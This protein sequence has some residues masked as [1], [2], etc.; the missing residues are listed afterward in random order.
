M[1]GIARRRDGTLRHRNAFGL[2]GLNGQAVA[3]SP[4]GRRIAVLGDF[5]G[6]VLVL[7]AVGNVLRRF[8]RLGTTANLALDFMDD[9]AVVIPA[10][11][12]LPAAMLQIVPAAG[13]APARAIPGPEP[14]TGSASGNVAQFYAVSADGSLAACLVDGAHPDHLTMADLRSGRIWNLDLKGILASYDQIG[15]VALSADARQLAVGTGENRI[16]LLDPVSGRLSSQF[17]VYPDNVDAGLDSIAFSPDGSA[18]RWASRC[19]PNGM[20][21]ADS[22]PGLTIWSIP[23]RR[24]IRA[25]ETNAQPVPQLSWSPDGRYV[26]AFVDRNEGVNQLLLVDTSGRMPDARRGIADLQ[27]LRFAANAPVLVLLTPRRI[28]LMSL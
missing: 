20:T 26:A 27:S 19:P 16:L 9:D 25:I 7:D 6:D 11:S 13:D 17:T 5:G 24:L 4:N 14:G 23:D 1:F 2:P 18:W 28:E 15:A 22:F 12:T 21:Q 8:P 10:S 3:V